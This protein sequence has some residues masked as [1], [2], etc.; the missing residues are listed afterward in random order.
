MIIDKRITGQSGK[1][2]S[3][4][5]EV[6]ITF[7]AISD[8][9]R[10]GT[11]F[12]LQRG[13]ARR[14]VVNPVTRAIEF[15][16]IDNLLD[17][18]NDGK[19]LGW[20]EA[21]MPYRFGF[22]HDDRIVATEVQVQDRRVLRA[23]SPFDLQ[24]I[25]NVIKLVPQTRRTGLVM[26]TVT[27]TFK[28]RSFENSNPDEEPSEDDLFTL[29]VGKEWFDVPFI[30]DVRTNKLII[31]SAK[32]EFN[33]VPTK[34]EAIR[35]FT[36]SRKERQNRMTLYD[37][38]ENVVNA[39]WWYGAKPG[40][41]L[42]ESIVPNWDGNIFTVEYTWKYNRRGWGEKYLDTGLRE[43]KENVQNLQ[44]LDGNQFT[45]KEKKYYP[46]LSTG[47]Q[48]P[49]EEPVKL[50]GTG[51]VPVHKA[52][53]IC[54]F[55]DDQGQAMTDDETGEILWYETGEIVYDVLADADGNPISDGDGNYKLIPRDYAN[56]P[57]V[58]VPFDYPSELDPDSIVYDENQKVDVEKSIFRPISEDQQH[59]FW[60]YRAMN[61]NI[62]KLPNPYA[63]TP[64]NKP[65]VN[66][67]EW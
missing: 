67:R 21:G 56:F 59:Y 24:I 14:E 16:P 61:F 28:K 47:S 40:T 57:G 20:L 11:W 4:S 65:D 60:K 17:P 5:S 37:Q 22:E 8:D 54:P 19:T 32:D 13:I 35:T 42:M 36:L 49:V 45:L 43:L 10:D 50:D 34:R 33:P 27:Q 3:E 48:T 23:D 7:Q 46:I 30:R 51:K 52:T 64:M 12:I 63:V 1:Y 62:L 25:N 44:D 29:R 66:N 39:D 26:W 58:D 6:T 53:K 9:W 55:I 18:D 15:V 31:N 38:Y 41:I 2:D